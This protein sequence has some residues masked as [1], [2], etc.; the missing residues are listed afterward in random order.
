[1]VRRTKEEAQAT[2]NRILDTAE[3]VFQERGVS[4]T[5][6]EAIAAAAGLT[7]G[8]IYW[9]FKDKSELFHAMMERV[10]LPMEDGADGDAADDPLGALREDFVA[11]LRRVVD[12]AQVQRVLEVAVLKVEY[13]DELQALRGRHLAARDVCVARTESALR[14]AVRR[15]QVSLRVPARTAALGVHALVSGLL[16]N[17]MLDRD[18][19][20][21][22]KVGRHALEAYLAG[23]VK[24]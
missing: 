17:W 16:R 18:A 3:M 8:A 12:D 9:H 13:V 20:D 15:G 23:L 7:R 6:L 19:F 11:A 22:V 10:I 24:A 4:R 2:R 1:M 21:L 5:T 14:R